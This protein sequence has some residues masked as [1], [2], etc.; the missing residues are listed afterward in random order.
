MTNSVTSMIRSGIASL[1]QASVRAPHAVSVNDNDVLYSQQ[2]QVDV[3]NMMPNERP[4]PVSVDRDRR[5]GEQLEHET[6]MRIRDALYAD[7]QA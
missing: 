3:Y 5:S 4:Q 2:P 7:R 1:V 6:L